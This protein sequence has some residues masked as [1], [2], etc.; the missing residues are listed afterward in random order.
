MV[1]NVLV[2]VRLLTSRHPV[3]DR[4]DVFVHSELCLLRARVTVVRDALRIIDA[5]AI[6]LRRLRM[7]VIYVQGGPNCLFLRRL[8][9]LYVVLFR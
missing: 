9:L 7:S 8:H 3:M 6:F 4:S 2:L 1:S 5:A